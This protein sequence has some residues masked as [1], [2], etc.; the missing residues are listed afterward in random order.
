MTGWASTGLECHFGSFHGKF[1]RDGGMDKTGQS[2]SDTV[3]CI[4]FNL[5]ADFTVGTHCHIIGS[6]EMITLKAAQIVGLSRHLSSFRI[7]F[8]ESVFYVFATKSTV[9]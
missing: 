1:G 3:V 5:M 7:T 6:I 2:N 9:F 4:Y 8:S